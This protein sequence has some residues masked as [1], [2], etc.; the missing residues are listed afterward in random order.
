MTDC[1][2]LFLFD[3]EHTKLPIGAFGARNVSFL[4]RC[5]TFQM[6]RVQLQNR[7]LRVSMRSHAAVPFFHMMPTTTSL[8]KIIIKKGEHPREISHNLNMLFLHPFHLEYVPCRGYGHN[9]WEENGQEKKWG[10]RFNCPIKKQNGT[11]TSTR[12]KLSR[13]YLY[14]CFWHFPS[15]PMKTHL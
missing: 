6:K 13:T 12:C 11:H 10:Q 7:L 2:F 3:K 1:T 5:G 9:V 8:A 15:G 14:K 4:P